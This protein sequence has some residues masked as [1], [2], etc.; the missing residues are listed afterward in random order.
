MMF[1]MVVH[2]MDT[3]KELYVNTISFKVTKDVGRGDMH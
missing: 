2:T 3:P 1:H